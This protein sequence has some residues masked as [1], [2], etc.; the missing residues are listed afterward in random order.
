VFKKRPRLINK[1]L[2]SLYIRETLFFACKLHAK[3]EWEKRKY[4][5]QIVLL[6]LLSA[7]EQLVLKSH[8]VLR[9]ETHASAQDVDQ[10]VSLLAQSIDNRRTGRNQGSL[11]SNISTMPIAHV[12]EEE[13]NIP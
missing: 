11:K 9:L 12:E 13:A 1:V 4:I 8:V 5:R 6:K 2:T 10:C 3:K 7:L